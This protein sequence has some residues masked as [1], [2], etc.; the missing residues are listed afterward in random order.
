MLLLRVA[1]ECPQYFAWLGIKIVQMVEY[2]KNATWESIV[3]PEQEEISLSKFSKIDNL[4][5]KNVCQISTNSN[6][7]TL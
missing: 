4:L 2:L 1:I 3:V 5:K 7:S 6:T